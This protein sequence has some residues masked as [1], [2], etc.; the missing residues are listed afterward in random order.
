MSKPKIKAIFFDA[1]G[2]L[3]DTAP[4]ITATINHVLAQ[5][6]RE[7]VSVQQMRPVISAGGQGLMRTAF[8]IDDDKQIKKLAQRLL[9]H[10]PQFITHQLSVFEGYYP[11]LDQLEQ[12]G[13]IW[14]VVS[15]KHESFLKTQMQHVELHHRSLTCI[16]GDTYKNK[17]P[18]P[19]PLLEACK[20]AGI[21]PRETIYIGDCENDVIAAKRADMQA[22]IVEFGYIPDDGSHL[23]WGADALLSHPADILKQP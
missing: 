2:T 18:H 17:K 9:D 11:L 3:L 19:Q 6:N 14:G 23:K 15:N 4:S 20:I 21:S 8:G 16:G 12:R 10:Y 22:W 7:P 13:I 1:D 5:E